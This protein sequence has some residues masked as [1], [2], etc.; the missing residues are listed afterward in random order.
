MRPE[1]KKKADKTSVA[2]SVAVHTVLIGGV[3]YWAAKSGTLDPVLKWMDLVAAKKEEKQKEEPKPPEP[4]QQTQP[5]P[6]LPPPPGGAA[7]SATV[8]A[9]PPGAPAAMG[10]TFFTAPKRPPGQ[11]ITGGGVFGGTGTNTAAT[12]PTVMTGPKLAPVVA[13]VTSVVA[14]PVPKK[15]PP[16]PPLASVAKP[17]T[18]AA[19]FEQRA[20]ATAVT[21]AIG[22]E[23]ISSRSPRTRVTW[24]RR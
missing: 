24:W 4:T 14:A 16:P 2:I 3:A 22:S 19:V 12:A 1:R 8:S 7:R 11:G 5:Q 10:G 6:N 9:A 13:P 17:T 21:D 15:L 20:K 23:Q 18:I